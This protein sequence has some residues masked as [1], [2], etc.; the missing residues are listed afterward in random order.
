MDLE[1]WADQVRRKAQDAGQWDEDTPPQKRRREARGWVLRE[2]I[3]TDRRLA[4]EG[5]GVVKV[6]L[7]KPKSFTGLPLLFEAPWSLDLNAQWALIQILLDSLRYQGIVSFGEFGL[8]HNDEIFKPR[9]FDFYMRGANSNPKKNIYTWEPAE[10]RTNKRLDYLHRLL[11]R[12]GLSLDEATKQAMHGL[13]ELWSAIVHPNG[14]LGKLFEGGLSH[15]GESNLWRL[16][17]DWWQVCL[18]G[19]EDV[20]RCDT[21]GTISSFSVNKVCPLTNCRGEM[22]PYHLSERQKNH[23]HNIFSK[24]TPIP[25]KVREHTA[26]L[27]K[28]E[29]FRSQHEFIAGKVNMLSCTTTFEMGVDVG[30]LQCVFMRNMP[31]NP[32]NY[33]QRAGRA[34]RRAE[35]TAIIVTYAQ[36]R[37][38]D[39]AYFD[40]WDHMVKG[41]VRPP[42]LHINNVK[43]AR[44]HVHAEALAEYYHQYPTAFADK[45]ESLFD[46]N[47]NQADELFNFLR[48]R[49]PLLQEKLERLMPQQLHHALGLDDWMWLSTTR[50]EGE[51]KGESFEE[52]L[53][54]AKID[55]FGDWKALE[56]AEE[57]ASQSRKHKIA[58]I[59]ANQLNTLKR[60]S[61]LGKLGTY[62]LM[63][64]YGF[65]TEVV[66]LKVRSSSREASQVELA[67]DMKLALSEFAPGNQVVANGMVW[68]SQGIVL[69]SGERKLHE[70]WYW[71]CP[72]C[73]F[74]S[75]EDVVATATAE[76]C[77][78]KTCHCG[79][80]IEAK[81]YVFPE[82]GFTTITG[83]GDHVGEARPPMKTYS[84]VFFHG[85]EGEA[86]FIPLPTFSAF[87]FREKEYGWIHVIN[88]NRD[89]RFWVC[90]NCGFVFNENP[91][92]TKEK[93]NTH[94]KPWTS[95]KDCLNTNLENLAL[96]YRYRT[97]V[98]E[99]RPPVL[100]REKLNLKSKEEYRSLWLST[101]Y[102]INNA[103]CRTLEIDERDLGACLHYQRRG[104][105]NFVLFDTAPGGAG[106]VR[107]VKDHFNEVVERALEILDQDCCRDDT[108][109][110]SCLRTYYNQRDHNFLCR[111]LA[112]DYLCSFVV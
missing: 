31:P 58:A 60:R 70:Y 44:R 47:N 87:S 86:D 56:K 74:F 85:S 36:R 5:A 109:C 66:E 9:N 88:S 67:R 46:P 42:V 104:H 63:P 90:K 89:R 91:Y 71:N 18:T 80:D 22:Q 52:R 26:Q 43:I 61:L 21:C 106:F 69:P 77:S 68:T 83:Q 39:Y 3:A 23:Y 51:A 101:L 33:V 95:D 54:K 13:K 82:F 96:G 6:T 97:D 29:A 19:D 8:E 64:K 110:I 27:T 94:R 25:L 28:D 35:G 75:S 84:D 14:P 11:L 73:Q 107:E 111:G 37:S 32:G 98:L 49:P 16:K 41:A 7:R 1:G 62:G 34:G 4:L 103:A 12:Q 102:A 79:N 72:Q 81:R 38:H 17:P 105:P 112:R 10:H 100:M 40:R 20:F 53:R 57:E 99:L 92:H 48:K 76:T 78:S 24:M 50:I 59:Y 93:K 30:D 45:L 2:W 108:S 55:V 15:S 65:P